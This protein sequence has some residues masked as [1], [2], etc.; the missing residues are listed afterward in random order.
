MFKKIKECVSCGCIF[1]LFM[2]PCQVFKKMSNATTT[3]QRVVE[4]V[5]IVGIDIPSFKV[6]RSDE[7]PPEAPPEYIDDFLEDTEETFPETKPWPIS[8]CFASYIT[9]VKSFIK[10]IP[11]LKHS[12]GDRRNGNGREG[13]FVLLFSFKNK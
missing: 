4:E 10:R 12:D 7:H 1:I 5:D 3:R 2:Q 13:S 6:V 9:W 8:F 11:N